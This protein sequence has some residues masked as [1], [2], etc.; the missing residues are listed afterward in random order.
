M[1]DTLEL[2]CQLKVQEKMLLKNAEREERNANKER[3]KA[4]K[5][6]SQGNKDLARLYATNAVRSQN[7]A[8]FLQ[9]NAARISSMVV[10]LKMSEVQKKMAKSLD[11]VVK[12]MAKSVGQMDLEKIAASTLKYDQIRG[13]ASMAGEIMNSPEGAVDA[14]SADLLESLE[15][16]IMVEL[17]TPILDIPT[18]DKPVKEQ[19][20]Q[21]GP[22]AA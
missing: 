17:D 15:N 11:M 14:E 20:H 6:L 16:E 8:L 4:K 7:H 12:E 1:A 13:K 18:T 5:A 22:T 19:G 10:D 3:N 2:Q 21:E 9:Q